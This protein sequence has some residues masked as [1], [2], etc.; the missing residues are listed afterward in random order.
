MDFLLDYSI[1]W[2]VFGQWVIVVSLLLNLALYI[3][4]KWLEKKLHYSTVSIDHLTRDLRN[5]I[6]HR[7]RHE[8]GLRL[9]NSELN[10]YRTAYENL[11]NQ[12]L[13][14]V[15]QHETLKAVHTGVTEAFNKVFERPKAK[16]A[17][18]IRPSESVRVK[19]LIKKLRKS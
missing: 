17:K 9:A 5:E 12:L 8:N 7:T 6:E 18:S 15:D 14:E 19:K 10:K 2:F 13:N 1:D 3:R 11:D 16:K 4:A